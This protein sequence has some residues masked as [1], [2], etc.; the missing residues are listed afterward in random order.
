M[1]KKSQ[2]S[3]LIT[4]GVGSIIAVVAAKFGSEI[5]TMVK[6]VPVIGEWLNS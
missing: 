3:W 2:N 1:A 6:D 5:K 4:L